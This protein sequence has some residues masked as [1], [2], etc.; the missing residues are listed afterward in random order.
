VQGKL[1]VDE[2]EEKQMSRGI[3]QF[4]LHCTFSGEREECAAS[5]C[6]QSSDVT[7]ACSQFTQFSIRM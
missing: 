2:E 3:I 7:T 1:T 4:I 5:F 6:G